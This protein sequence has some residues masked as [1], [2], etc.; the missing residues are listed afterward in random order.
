[1]FDILQ[2][3][4]VFIKS[5]SY[6]APVLRVG[7]SQVKGEEVVECAEFKLDMPVRFP[8]IF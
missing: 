7:K 1:M 3:R 2:F 8:Y 4:K 5:D 6:I